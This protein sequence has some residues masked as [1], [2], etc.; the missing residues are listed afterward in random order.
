MAVQPNT[1]T[2]GTLLTRLPTSVILER[3][4]DEAE[5]ETITLEWIV[6]S[7]RDRSFGIIMVLIS[8]VGLVPGIAT[9]AGLLL[10]VPAVQMLLAHSGPVLP[11]F[12]AKREVSRKKFERLVVRLIPVLRWMERFVRPRWPTPFE[13]TKRLVGFVILLLCVTLLTPIPFSHVLPLFAV[14]LLAF[15]FLEE[16]GVCLAISLVLALVSIVISL[17]AV[18]GTIEAGLLL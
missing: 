9:V 15:A 7:L 16:D 12:I 4:L 1:D 17:A 6:A 13:M 14:M 3:L 11:G 8:L 2:D 10:A 5:G 18:W